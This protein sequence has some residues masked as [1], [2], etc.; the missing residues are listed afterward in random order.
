MEVNHDAYRINPFRKLF[1]DQKE[2]IKK[3]PQWIQHYIL[4]IEKRNDMLT[5]ILNGEENTSIKAL[6]GSEGVNR[7]I[8]DRATIRFI[9]NNGSHVDIS[10]SKDHLEVFTRDTAIIIPEASN[11]FHIISKRSSEVI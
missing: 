1:K 7:N 5:S 8:P 11:H 9:M 3:L 6:M 2:K 10:F 4:I